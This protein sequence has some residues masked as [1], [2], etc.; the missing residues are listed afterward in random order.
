LP[1][2][3]EEL[4]AGALALAAADALAEADGLALAGADLVGVAVELGQLV[5]VAVAVA[6][7]VFLLVALVLAAAG[8]V[9][10]V[11]LA[12]LTA[13]L[14]LSVALVMS[15]GL[16]LL[17]VGLPL[18]L[19]LVLALDGLVGVTSEVAVGVVGL[20]A[21]D[22]ADGEEPGGHGVAARLGL[23]A[24]GLPWPPAPADE[25]TRTPVPA[26]LP[27]PPVLLAENTPPTELP[28]LTSAWC[29]GGTARAMP[30]ANT[31]QAIARAG[32]SSPSR[33][34]RAGRRG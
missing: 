11:L 23:P 31:A 17:L 29:S 3:L 6:L 16:E 8:G 9:E 30:M 27:A 2:D 26:A 34:S 20:L 1:F 28:K 24:D 12:A 18:G 13:G 19:P 21:V 33:Q 22:A 25:G 15:L 14:A 5:P 32:R 7:C 4:D 10:V